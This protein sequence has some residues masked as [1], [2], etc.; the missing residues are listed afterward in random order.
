MGK[1]SAPARPLLLD[2]RP[3]E[4]TPTH[5]VIGFDPEFA[6]EVADFEAVRNRQAVEH[7]LRRILH[8]A[9][10]VEFRVAAEGLAEIDVDP[11]VVRDEPAKAEAGAAAAVPAP[12]PAGPAARSRTVAQWAREPAVQRVLEVFD[13]TIINVR[14][15]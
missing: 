13:G 12:A 2:A 4:V 8:R 3:L 5:V 10:H 11:Y 6:S 1:E 14:D 7:A 15:G 9:V